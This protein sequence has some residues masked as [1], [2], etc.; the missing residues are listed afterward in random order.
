MFLISLD[1][2]WPFYLIEINSCR[3]FYGQRL[4]LKLD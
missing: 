4:L 2:L 3:I 1:R